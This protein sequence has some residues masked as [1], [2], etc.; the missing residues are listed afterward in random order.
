MPKA[1]VDKQRDF[2]PPQ[3][4][5]RSSRQLLAVKSKTKAQSVNNGTHLQF[6]GGISVFHSRHKFAAIRLTDGVHFQH[7]DIRSRKGGIC[8]LSGV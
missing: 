4:N 3:N 8:Q 2:M 6:G 5:I 7:S 1:S